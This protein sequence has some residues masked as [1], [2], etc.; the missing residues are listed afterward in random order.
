[1]ERRIIKINGIVQ[2]V[3]FRPFIYNL[4]LKHSIKGYVN[5][6]SE[7]VLI[8]AEAPLE[9]LQE[10]IKEIKLNAPPLSEIHSLECFTEEYKGYDG[11]IIEESRSTEG[12]ITL[13]SPDTAIC[14][15]CLMDIKDV[16]NKRYFY[17]FTNCTNCGPRFSIIKNIPYDRINTTMDKFNMCNDCNEEY[18]N[19]LNRR[20]H[21]QPNGCGD[22]GPHIYITDKSGKEIHITNYEK[23][24]Y[25][26]NFHLLKWTSKKLKEGYIFAIKG[27]TGFHLVCSGENP[28]AVNKLRI[29]K[30]RPHKPFALM[31]KDIDVI[32]KHCIVSKKEEELLTGHEKPIV[33]LHK[34]ES[35]TLPCS[36][37]PNKKNVG[38][39]LPYT[40]LHALLFSFD[41]EVLVMT[42]ANLSSLPLEYE[43]SKAVKHLSHIADYFLL[44][45][46]DIYIPVDDSVCRVEFDKEYMLRR[47]RGYAP[48]PFKLKTKK[49]ILALGPH[50]KNTFCLCKG[51]FVFLSQ[52]IGDLENIETYNHYVN[53]IKHYSEIYNIKPEAAVCDLHPDYASTKYAEGIH[54]PLLKVQHHH[55]HIASCMINNSI[56]HKV[57]GLSFDGTG[58]GDDGAIWGGEFLICDLNG[59]KRAAHIS[60]T[61]LPSGDSAAKD[62]WKTAIAY[63][64]HAY[65]INKEA[66]YLPQLEFVVDK[67][68]GKKGMLF[69]KIISNNINTIPSSS[70]GRFFDAVSSLCGINHSTTYEGQASIELESILEDLIYEEYYEYKINYK[71]GI[72]IIE[73]HNIIIEIVK[74]LLAGISPKII[75]LKFHNTIISFSKDMC[76]ILRKQ[77]GINDA[78]LSG[79]VFQNSYILNNLHKALNQEGFKV[80]THSSIPANDGGISIGQLAIADA[81][82]NR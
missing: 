62:P 35:S 68:Y 36:I 39:M 72:Y 6:N 63:L 71:S 14:S 51:D 66:S 65:S 12:K 42:S 28:D 77:Y 24:R 55:A 40:P 73:T 15:E 49:S 48:Y 9:K 29:R 41:E 56:N 82:Y 27:L 59:Y 50:M 58:Y 13:I 21:A 78:A 52:H 60:Y 45:N 18:T 8:D 23:H 76:L 69:L 31:A 67:F 54:L 20:F 32:K 44:H 46:R 30:N 25:E 26:Y 1:M 11:F 2:G 7:G 74:D 34:K 57:I 5:N 10:F 38:F 37:A 16:N 43:N 70:M 17:P 22:C 75:S 81:L 4:A 79:G 64:Y 47:A 80:Y 19:P 3:G 61:E 53:N 33:I